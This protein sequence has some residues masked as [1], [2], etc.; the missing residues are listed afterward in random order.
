M[1][2]S[3][4][5]QMNDLNLLTDQKLVKDV[6]DHVQ[7]LSIAQKLMDDCLNEILI[8]QAYDQVQTIKDRNHRYGEFLKKLNNFVY[9][10]FIQLFELNNETSQ[11]WKTVSKTIHKTFTSDKFHQQLLFEN[12]KI[13]SLEPFRTES[14]N[15]YDHVL[16]LS[17]DEVFD[18]IKEFYQKGKRAR[19]SD[20]FINLNGYKIKMTGLKLKTFLDDGQTCSCC[21]MKATFFSVS[22]IKHLKSLNSYHLSLWGANSKGELVQFTHDHTLARSLGGKNNVTNTTTMCFKC[23]NLKSAKETRLSKKK[24]LKINDTIFI[25]VPAHP[26]QPTSLNLSSSSK[27]KEHKKI[28]IIVDPEPKHK[29][30]VK[31][32]LP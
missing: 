21:G 10:G 7:Q 20:P 32:V 19:M 14:F 9:T 16:Y 5:H 15:S 28:I 13:T 4:N 23:N 11:L 29:K 30:K 8:K 25:N 6:F 26:S 2:F 12:E 17:V 3:Q 27:K 18:L 31:K 22:K 24:K 1:T